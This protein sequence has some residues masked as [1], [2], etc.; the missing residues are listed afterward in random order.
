VLDAPELVDDEDEDLFWA[1]APGCSA[2]IAAAMIAT[3]TALLI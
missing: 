3:Q 1:K 2:S